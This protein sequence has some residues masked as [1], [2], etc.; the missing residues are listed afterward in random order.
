MFCTI[1]D[2]PFWPSVEA[3]PK[4]P[5]VPPKLHKPSSKS[6]KLIYFFGSH[7]FAWVHTSRILAWEENTEKP[8]KSRA[9]ECEYA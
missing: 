8:S 2:H 7:D 4:H 5:A 6:H 3:D 1:G 9:F